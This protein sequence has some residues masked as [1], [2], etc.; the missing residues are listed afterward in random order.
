MTRPIE[1][2][3]SPIFPERWSPRAFDAAATLSDADLL[4]LFE[5]ARWAPSA[6]NSQPWRFLYA[7][8]GGA[9]WAEYLDCLIPFNRA[10]AEHASVLVAALSAQQFTPPGSD[11]VVV[12]G[13]HSFDTGAAVAYLALQASIAGWGAHII[14]GI[15]K[16]KARKS[17]NVPADH[18]VEAF[19][20]IGKRGN[21][22][23]LPDALKAREKPS[24]REAL[25]TRVA[26]GRFAF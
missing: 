3:V 25:G 22:D 24:E 15:D 2:G 1:R 7:R 26:E 5:A 20:V 14:S 19:I 21:P 9:F 8:R 23:S 18:Q 13:S 16:E 12:T 17:L 4:R 10:W 11:K 6:Y